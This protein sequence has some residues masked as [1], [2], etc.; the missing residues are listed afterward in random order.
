M[1]LV[2]FKKLTVPVSDENGLLKWC[3]GYKIGDRDPYLVSHQDNV[4]IF[5][6]VEEAQKYIDDDE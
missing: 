1:A 5:D 2:E 3:I 4:L 6:T